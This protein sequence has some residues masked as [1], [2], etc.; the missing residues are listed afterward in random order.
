MTPTKWIR[1][2][3]RILALATS[4]RK[5][6]AA[7]LAALMAGFTAPL[8]GQLPADSVRRIDGIF[9]A[10]D[11][12]DTPGCVVGADRG[13]RP[14]FR[15]AYG[16]ANL[17]L[18]VPLTVESVL[19]TGSVAKQFVAG[20]IVSLATSGALGLD[21]PIRRYLPELPE[22]DPP[23]TIRMLLNHTGDIREL[24]AL[25]AMAGL[26]VGSVAFTMDQA[27]ALL[28]R[29][30]GG[31]F[32]PNSRYAY[33]NGGY[34]LLAEIVKRASGRSLADYGRTTFF[35]PLGMRAT[36]WRDDWNRVVPSRATA[37]RPAGTGFR[38]DMPITSV[39]GNGGLLTTISDLLVWNE[40]LAHPRV[41]G[42]GWT[43]SLERTGRLASGRELEY[44]LGLRV[45][46]YR[47]QREVSHFGNTASYW[48]Y[49]GRFPE[50][51]LSVAVLCNHGG[52]DAP[53]LAR[54]VI[55]L[56]LPAGSPPAPTIRIPPGAP[57]VTAYAGRY[58][59]PNTED[60]IDIAIR[61]GFLVQQRL[62]RT[63]PLTPLGAGRYG[64]DA[65]IYGQASR[66][67]ALTFAE[68]VAG[69]AP[70]VTLTTPDGGPAEYVR[71]A[72]P[73][74]SAAELT[75]YAGVYHGDELA[76]DYRIRSTG[77][78][79]TLEVLGVGRLPE[80]LGGPVLTLTRNATDAFGDAGGLT[81]R[82]T[83]GSGRVTGFLLHFHGAMISGIRFRREGP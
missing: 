46:T 7:C 33:S 23:V 6:T 75:H 10:F 28:L 5:R 22:R 70:K 34:V 14:L 4:G 76:A 21:D 74:S 50:I 54:Q 18:G 78:A 9:A 51:G 2:R 77:T 52:A 41:G 83:R 53:G 58:R 60:L 64:W 3:R 55:D 68:P 66:P 8:V 40:Q 1:T 20:S 47:G 62:G 11:H 16:M 36:Q 35:E 13:G 59:D 31:D 79:L 42:A 17:E 39:H 29:Q 45:T 44:A 43:D 27:L 73:R 26:P 48:S 72:P 71:V 80:D 24:W 63:V 30:R 19:E 49:L 82:F 12:T 69:R 38:I 25:F 81:V 65:A 37:Y 56:L 32:A 67:M 61:D 15:R 57:G